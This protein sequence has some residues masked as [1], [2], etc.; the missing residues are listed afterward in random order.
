VLIHAGVPAVA[1]GDEALVA[2]QVESGMVGG[3]TLRA[4]GERLAADLKTLPAQRIDDA[5][6]LRPG[7]VGVDR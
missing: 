5:Q 2:Q 4:R 3:N 6:P 7:R 1:P